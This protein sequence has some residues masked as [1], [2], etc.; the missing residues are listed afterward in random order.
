MCSKDPW[1][2]ETEHPSAP[3]RVQLVR[4]N[5]L[6][7]KVCW[8]PCQTADTYLLQLQT[9]DIP[10]TPAA[11]SLDCPYGHTC[12]KGAGSPL[13]AATAKPS[14]VLKVA[15]APGVLGGA[16]VVMVKQTT[17][18][19]TVTVATLPAGVRMVVPAQP[20]QGTPIGN[21]P[22]MSG[23][24]VLATAAA[25]TQKIAPSTATVLNVPAGATMV[26]TAAV[27]PGSSSLP[28]QVATPVTMVRF[29]SAVRG[30]CTWLIWVLQVFSLNLGPFI[31]VEGIYLKCR[32]LP[33]AT[34]WYLL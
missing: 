26:K 18:K 27:S 1:Y 32:L 16:S 15:A 17:A 8:G 19:P 31:R 24:A 22:Q 25:A 5:T 3:S 20:I 21:S 14:G 6:S 30:G 34:F 9:H 7:L 10:I 33:V 2:L 12:R 29:G 4:A 28:V 11:S 23:M 13:A